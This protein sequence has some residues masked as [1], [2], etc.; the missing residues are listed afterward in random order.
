MLFLH[1]EFLLCCHVM[2]V[3]SFKFKATLMLARN[4]A[5]IRTWNSTPYYLLFL[6]QSLQFYCSKDWKICLH[7][8]VVE[9]IRLE[10]GLKKQVWIMW[11]HQFIYSSNLSVGCYI[12][13]VHCKKITYFVGH[14]PYQSLEWN[15]PSIRQC[16]Q[17]DTVEALDSVYRQTLWKH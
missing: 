9:Y 15:L 5:I 10:K 17:T 13:S 2:V 14:R 16:L 8:R 7:N 6:L 11:F 1:V 12:L 4:L 3:N